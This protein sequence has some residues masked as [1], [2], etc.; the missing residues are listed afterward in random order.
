MV[1]QIRLFIISCW[2]YQYIII[3]KLFSY[4]CL[5]ASFQH[6]VC[7]PVRCLQFSYKADQQK[8]YNQTCIS[9]LQQSFGLFVLDIYS[10][11]QK[12]H[13]NTK[14]NEKTSLY[15]YAVKFPDIIS[16]IFYEKY[17]GR[18]RI[19]VVNASFPDGFC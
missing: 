10:H 2:S 5:M 13:E 9:I 7:K 1:R 15:I 11:L 16:N 4:R 17:Y 12:K 3:H 8:H 18:C 14:L 6:F 19:N